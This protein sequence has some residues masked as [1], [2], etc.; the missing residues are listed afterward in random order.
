[1]IVIIYLILFSFAIINSLW[2]WYLLGR[3]E[4]FGKK[5]TKSKSGTNNVKIVVQTLCNMYRPFKQQEN[6]K[7]LEDECY[8]VSVWD[9]NMFSRFAGD[10]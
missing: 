9:E 8:G 7:T 10:S 4:E 5:I 1:M 3:N 6:S 2:K